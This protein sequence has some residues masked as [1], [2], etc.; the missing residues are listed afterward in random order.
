MRAVSKYLPK[1]PM[2]DI[3]FHSKSKK[4]VQHATVTYVYFKNTY[5]ELGTYPVESRS[6]DRELRS[7]MIQ[8]VLEYACFAYAV[9]DGTSCRPC[10]YTVHNQN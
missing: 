3:P 7:I 1:P 4:T 6:H 2:L 5:P 8:L 10:N 9:S